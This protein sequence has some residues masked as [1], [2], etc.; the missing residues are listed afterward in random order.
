MKK[1]IPNIITAARILG[2]AVLLFI[3]PLTIP[4]YIIYSL[5]GLSDAVDGFIAR[6][7]KTQSTLGAKLDSIADLTFYAVMFLKVF[8]TMFE[9]LELYVWCVG[10]AAL[11]IRIV[12]YLF[13]AVKYRKFSSLHTVYNKISGLMVFLI[14]YSLKFAFGMYYCLVAAIMSNIAAIHE[15]ILHLR[16][17]TYGAEKTNPAH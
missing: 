10:F 4:F 16:N 2:A 6:A 13:V 17:R 7:M 9:V 12:S 14:P 3:E 1:N 8:P 15:F 11:F 5:C